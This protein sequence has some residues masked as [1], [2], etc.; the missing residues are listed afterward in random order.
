MF[1]SVNCSRAV[2][3]YT[4]P[5]FE[6]D[7]WIVPKGIADFIVGRSRGWVVSFWTDSGTVQ[8]NKTSFGETNAGSAWRLRNADIYS[9][10]DTQCRGR[11]QQ[12]G[13][14]TI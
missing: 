12:I 5:L 2:F 8:E 3:Q 7:L 11:I 4:N 6:G 1:L 9:T 14:K 13:F 10:E